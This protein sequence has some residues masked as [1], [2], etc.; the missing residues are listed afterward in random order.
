MH[1]GCIGNGNE[2]L[3]VCQVGTI[4]ICGINVAQFHTRHDVIFP[5]ELL[6]EVGLKGIFLLMEILAIVALQ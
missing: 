2:S 3:I 5:A 4:L 6:P 1:A